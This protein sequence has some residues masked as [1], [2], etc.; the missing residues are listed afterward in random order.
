MRNVAIVYNAIFF[1]NWTEEEILKQLD[2]YVL[3]SN[4]PAHYYPIPGI[5]FEQCCVYP[6]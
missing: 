3:D 6:N 5:Q 2:Q 1:E 4:Y